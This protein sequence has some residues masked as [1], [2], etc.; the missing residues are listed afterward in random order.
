MLHTPR[1]RPGVAPRAGF[2][3]ARMTMKCDGRG[4]VGCCAAKRI[5]GC[6]ACPAAEWARG[7]VEGAAVAH[8]CVH[9][10][11]A[12]PRDAAAAAVLG[13]G[14]RAAAASVCAAT[15]D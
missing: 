5:H 3:G 12:A 11:P 7:A 14:C 2:S 4:G 13:W 1:G 9:G 10:V 6:A 8:G 15:D